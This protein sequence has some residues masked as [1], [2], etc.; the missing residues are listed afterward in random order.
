ML[1]ELKVPFELRVVVVRLYESVI[2]KFRTIEGWWEE[3]NCNVGVKQGFPLSPTLFRM[4]IYK[5]QYWLEDVGCT[6]P[7]LTSIAIILLHV[8]DSVL[9]ERSPY[10]L[11]KHLIIIEMTYAL[12]LVWLWALREWKL[13]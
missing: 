5:L 9:M 3:I 11:S 13:W 7:T 6:H 2:S 1:E 10:D 8:D 12:V 4:Y